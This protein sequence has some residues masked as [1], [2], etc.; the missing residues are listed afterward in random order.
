MASGI[1]LAIDRD[2]GMTNFSPHYIFLC[3]GNKLTLSKPN[4]ELH[5]DYRSADNGRRR[6]TSLDW[7]LKWYF[8]S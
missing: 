3:G 8:W 1:L 5:M 6:D 4:Y 7:T 2:L